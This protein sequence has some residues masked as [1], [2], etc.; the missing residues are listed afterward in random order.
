LATADTVTVPDA[1]CPF[2]VAV[3]VA[4]PAPP[5]AVYVVEPPPRGE[6]EPGPESVQAAP[7]GLVGLPY[8]SVADA[9]NVWLPPIPTLAVLGETATLDADPASQDHVNVVLPE[10]PE[11]SV[12]VTVTVELP[13]VFG[14]V[15]L[16]SPL[17]LR[18]TLP[19]SPVA[20]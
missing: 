6:I 16:N 8:W 20:V 19:G 2:S 7:D 4:L 15:P 18:V 13:A 11:E 12:A 3:T 17:E 14:A 5:D 10:F 9:V 1:L